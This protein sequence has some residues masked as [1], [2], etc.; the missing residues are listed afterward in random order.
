MA[1]IG[2]VISWIASVA[3]LLLLVWAG[4]IIYETNGEEIGI[5]PAAIRVRGAAVIW[6]WAKAYDGFATGPV[7]AYDQRT[8]CTILQL[9][10]RTAEYRQL[11]PT[12]GNDQP[13]IRSGGPG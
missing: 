1:W 2:I 9:G 12:L 13:R 10:N 4:Y 6:I 11:S 3:T 7:S 8:R 5:G